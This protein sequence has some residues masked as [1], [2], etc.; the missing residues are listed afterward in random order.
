MKDTFIE[1]IGRD[2][3]A[4]TEVESIE[5]K[6]GDVVDRL[7][8]RTYTYEKVVEKVIGITR[9]QGRERKRDGTEI[10]IIGH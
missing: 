5:R 7:I 6:I 9:V 4:E 3:V 1:A 10:L 8:Q 2:D